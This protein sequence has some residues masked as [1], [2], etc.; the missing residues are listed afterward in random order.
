MSETVGQVPAEP[1]KVQD[2]CEA[3]TEEANGCEAANG[4]AENH[5]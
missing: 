5:G 4:N 2:A 1:V 3:A